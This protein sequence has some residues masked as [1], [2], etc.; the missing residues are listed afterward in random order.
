MKKLIPLLILI[1]TLF[2]CSDT[3]SISDQS[4]YLID[5]QTGKIMLDSDPNIILVD[6][7]TLAEYREIRIP[8]SLLLPLSTLASSATS[9]L[10]DKNAIIIIYCRSGNRS[11]DAVSILHGMGYTKLYDMG[12]IIDWPYDTISG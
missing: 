4:P 1:A 3:T 10:P 9:S 11:A 7:R 2:S 6:V 8:G 12:G 5:A